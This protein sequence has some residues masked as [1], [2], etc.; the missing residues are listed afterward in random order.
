MIEE[1]AMRA[2][3]LSR[4]GGPEV[5]ECV[6]LPRPVPRRGEILVRV[7]A[8]GVN[9][10]ETLLRADRYAVTPQLPM[11]LG[12]EAVGVVEGLGDGVTAPGLGERVAA[13]LFATD[14]PSGGYAEYVSIE[15]A[16]AVPVPDG[17]SAQT[18][19]ALMV[20]G[21]SALHLIRR[22]PPKGKSVLVTAA[23]GGLGSLVVQRAK[24]AGASRLIALA[25]S[26]EK[27]ALAKTLGADEG[28]DYTRP[29]WPGEVRR[30]T[31][32]IGADIIYDLVG[33]PASSACL[34]VLAECGELVFGALGRF[35]L[36]A[37]DLRR[38]I[39]KNQSLKGF[40]L[41]PLLTRTSLKVDLAH[42]FELAR[43][44]ELKVPAGKIFPLERAADAHHALESRRTTGKVVLTP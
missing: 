3:R 4:F 9:F 41:L 25:S 40:A 8:A 6:E 32:T 29:D 5:L 36:D 22:T 1:L 14:R 38:M 23:A 19:G 39:A 21:L 11:M 26:P 34:Q 35:D 30:I 15:A 28:I 27:L 7:E 18:A 13:P 43:S 17:P 37:D 20:Q 10:F 2:V 42:L 24:A 44:G 31:E 33:G 12:V 16:W